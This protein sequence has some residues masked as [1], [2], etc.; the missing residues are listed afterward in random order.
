MGGL[1]V[2]PL[3]IKTL[4]LADIANRLVID[5][6]KLTDYAL[7]TGSPRGRHKA[8]VFKKSLGFSRENYGDLLTQIKNQALED[9][10]TFHSEDGFGR[11][12]TVDLAIRGPEGQQAIVRTGWLVPPGTDEA[13]LITLYVRKAEVR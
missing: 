11:R 6:R 4:K 13:H 5:S 8:A 7:D 10:A 3:E 12:Y 2:F 9:E 1:V